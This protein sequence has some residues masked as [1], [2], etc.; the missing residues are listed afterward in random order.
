LH[1]LTRNLASV[2]HSWQESLQIS[3]FL[4]DAVSGERGAVLARELATENAVAHAL[5][6]SREA[7]LDEFRA[8]SGFGEA[9]ELLRDNP[10]PA[11]ISITPQR[12][13][14]KREVQSLLSR[15]AALPE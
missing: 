14:E 8:A 3:L 6:I 15:L 11:V 7:A 1:V 5:Y 12:N 13:L 2:G 10:L 4:K 9:L